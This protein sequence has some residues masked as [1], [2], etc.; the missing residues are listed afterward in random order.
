M[1]DAAAGL[2]TGVAMGTAGVWRAGLFGTA[3]GTAMGATAGAV[4][5]AGDTPATGFATG[6]EG[7][8]AGGTAGLVMSR[9]AA[10]ADG[11][12]TPGAAV[13][14]GWVML[15]AEDAAVGLLIDDA[16][17][18]AGLISSSERTSGGS[19]TCGQACPVDRNKAAPATNI[20]RPRMIGMAIFMTSFYPLTAQLRGCGGIV[21]AVDLCSGW[22]RRNGTP[23]RMR[24]VL[25]RKRTNA[26]SEYECRRPY[27]RLI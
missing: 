19:G 27:H 3:A 21:V 13:S 20:Q 24:R 1:S 5:C 7:D 9:T 4:A 17:G 26:W 23:S 25:M 22:I 15:G 8:T 16:G 2:T 11:C 18:F 12:A 6:A 14:A 10:G